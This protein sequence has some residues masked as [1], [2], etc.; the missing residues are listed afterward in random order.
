M[1]TTNRNGK[2]FTPIAFNQDEK[3]R[4]AAHA[5]RM[6]AYLRAN[7]NVSNMTEQDRAAFGNATQ[8]QLA[9]AMNGAVMG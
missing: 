1:K 2:F 7:G 3:A 9:A 4:R 6:S 5:R 8:A